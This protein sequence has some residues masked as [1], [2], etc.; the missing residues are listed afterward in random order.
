M[1]LV[2]QILVKKK[3]KFFEECDRLCFLS[4]N[5]YNA[6]LYRIK[7]Q[8]EKDSTF[9]GYVT[10]NKQMRLEDNVDFRAL[11]GEISAQTLMILERNYKSYFA[12]LKDYKKNPHKYKGT[13][14]PP[15]FKH[16]T[17]GRFVTIF[18]NRSVSKKEIKKGFLMLI[19]TSISFQTSFVHPDINQIRIVPQNN[20]D[21]CIEIVYEK[22][23]K[24]KVENNNYAGIDIGLNNLATIV[25]NTGT[26]PT[27]IN[28][29]PLKSINQYYNKK[30]ALMQSKLPFYIANDGTR[31][32]RT[33]SKNIR[34]LTIKRNNKIK[35]YLHKASRK[36]VN[37]LQQND[38][39]LVVVGQNKEWKQSINL[40]K[41]TNQNFV[42]IPHARFI[43]M[44]EYKAKL[45]GIELIIREESY[46]SKC[47]FLD[48]ET[49]RKHNEYLGKRIK[50]GLFRTSNGTKWNSD[51]NGAFNILK[52]EV[53]I[54]FANGI[55]GALSHPQVIKI[56]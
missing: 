41:A 28:G 13:P 18:T 10:V 5:V 12:A 37:H 44:C 29:K 30:K 42:A 46:T 32:Q 36:V 17:K 47:S 35:D 21:Y 15:M 25:A 50:R 14:K 7:Q 48:N 55:E 2:K 8:Y 19:G 9:L 51:C 43:S 3:S 56:F 16:R 53:P 23:E 26:R 39:S 4:K 1:K 27:I 45:D 52:K 20:G 31:K 49:I 33:S 6:Y 54:A 24:E 11:G 38:I 22:K 40:R 34:K